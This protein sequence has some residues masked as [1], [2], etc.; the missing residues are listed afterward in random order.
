MIS[1]SPWY[2]TWNAKMAND[3][4]AIIKA[5]EPHILASGHGEPMTGEGTLRELNA[6]ADQ[7]SRITAVKQRVK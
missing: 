7:I 2:S 6:F 1:G 4:V 3:S 5:L